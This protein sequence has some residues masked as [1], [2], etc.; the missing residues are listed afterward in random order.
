M[1]E[2][3]VA[4]TGTLRNFSGGSLNWTIETRCSDDLA[5]ASADC[6][7]K[8]PKTSKEACVRLRTLDDNDAETN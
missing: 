7:L 1:G 5:C 6:V 3:L 2:E 8:A 4:V